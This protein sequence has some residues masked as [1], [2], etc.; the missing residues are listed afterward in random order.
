[1]Y[2]L[3]C[4]AGFPM[5]LKEGKFHICGFSMAARDS[6]LAVEVVLV[7]DENIKTTDDWGK[8]LDSATGNKK[9]L[10][11]RKGIA[12]YGVPIDSMFL[13]EPIKTR[14]GLSIFAENVLGGSLCVYVR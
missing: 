11:H 10:M 5:P 12:T 9:V 14:Y 3:T 7:D 8:M 6:S 2:P 1:M 4:Y 13:T